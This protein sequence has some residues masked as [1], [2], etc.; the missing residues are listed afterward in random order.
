MKKSILT[1]LLF[2]LIGTSLLLG[3]AK[4]AVKFG[5]CGTT[6]N[7]IKQADISK[8]NVLMPLNKNLI[9]SSFTLAIFTKSTDAKTKGV[10]VDYACV[11]NKLSDAATDA[12]KKAPVGTKF[13]IESIVASDGKTES[14]YSGI[15]ME[16][17]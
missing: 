5:I 6:E 3:Q 1:F 16:I 9:I 8:C 11:G 14:K 12:L 2:T 10:Y 17:K 7:T 15:S 13:L 4:E